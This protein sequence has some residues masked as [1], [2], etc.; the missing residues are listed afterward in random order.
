MNYLYGYL[1]LGAI[2]MAINYF[3]S[4]S[5]ESRKVDL[6][7]GLFYWAYDP[8]GN[9]WWVKLLNNISILIVVALF[10]TV[11]P[12]GIYLD[13]KDFIETRRSRNDESSKEFA[14][15]K[16]HLQKRR[17][18]SEIEAAEVVMDPLGAVPKTPFGHLNPAWE[19]F[20]KSILEDDELWSFSAPWTTKFGRNELREGYVVM[21]GEMIG[22]HFLN[23]LVLIDE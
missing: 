3:L 23:R 8:R 14:V 9:R 11:W 1:A 12:I 4:Q 13:A 6:C 5:T 19:V 7:D 17:T 15:T 18:V 22:L 2:F 20:K 16:D 21:R 10:L